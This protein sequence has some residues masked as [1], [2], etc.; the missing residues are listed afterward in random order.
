MP[1]VCRLSKLHKKLDVLIKLFISSMHPGQALDL[2]R[3]ATG[4]VMPYYHMPVPPT[5]GAPSGLCA[6]P[7]GGTG[8]ATTAGPAGGTGAATTAGPEGAGGG[9]VHHWCRSTTGQA[10][11]HTPMKQAAINQLPERLAA[12]SGPF[13]GPSP[14]L[15]P[16]WGGGPGEVYGMGIMSG[17]PEGE[18]GP[19][20]SH[21]VSGCFTSE[22]SGRLEPGAAVPWYQQGVAAEPSTG[23]SC[24]SRASADLTSPALAGRADRSGSGS[25]RREPAVL[26]GYSRRQGHTTAEAAAAAG[27]SRGGALPRMNTTGHATILGYQHLHPLPHLGTAFAGYPPW[28]YPVAP[29]GTSSTSASYVMAEQHA[30]TLAGAVGTRNFGRGRTTGVHGVH[31]LRVG[32]PGYERVGRVGSEHRRLGSAQMMLS[33]SQSV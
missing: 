5:A 29:L 24:S 4:G 1:S 30:G 27:A 18:V 28:G 10:K 7:A 3:Q 11:P 12:V 17:R 23:G 33:R 15:W 25:S 8:A 6:R 9:A 20:A 16:G 22:G 13:V 26:H 14:G 32:L 2:S 31:S 21:L 19:G